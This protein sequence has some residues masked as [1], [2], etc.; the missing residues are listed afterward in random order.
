MIEQMI[1]ELNYGYVL[2]RF[3]SPKGSHSRW[4]IIKPRLYLICDSCECEMGDKAVRLERSGNI[5]IT[6]L[7]ITCYRKDKEARRMIH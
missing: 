1:K 2:E 7:C 3:V 6:T 5:V 4:R